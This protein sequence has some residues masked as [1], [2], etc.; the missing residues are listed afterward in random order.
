MEIKRNKYIGNFDK[1]LK[2]S[3]YFTKWICN[4]LNNKNDFPKVYCQ[5][6]FDL[7]PFIGNGG[8]KIRFADILLFDFKK[9]ENITFFIEAKDFGAMIFE[10]CTGLPK[11]YIDNKMIILGE[12][13]VY[14]VFKENEKTIHERKKHK[15]KLVFVSGRKIIPYG[16]RLDILMKNRNIELEFEIKSKFYKNRHNEQ[17]IWNLSA[18]NPIIDVFK[19]DFGIN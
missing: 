9:K 5:D 13:K 14:L 10:D 4:I 6:Q 15:R 18:C 3:R 2:E 17:Y 11:S 8:E 7:S 12:N 16:E 19:R 1:C